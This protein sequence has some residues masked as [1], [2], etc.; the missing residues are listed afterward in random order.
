MARCSVRSVCGGESKEKD[1]AA[2]AES[3]A[4]KVLPP[5]EAVHRLRALAKE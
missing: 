1:F 3:F 4:L 5:S 2:V